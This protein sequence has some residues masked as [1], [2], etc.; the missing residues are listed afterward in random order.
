MLIYVYINIC[1]NYINFTINITIL[2]LRIV[3]LTWVIVRSNFIK[4]YMKLSTK[5]ILMQ[6][7]I[8]FWLL[9]FKFY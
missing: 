8:L 5:V 3:I 6:L 7:W 4:N 9:V 1:I 2:F